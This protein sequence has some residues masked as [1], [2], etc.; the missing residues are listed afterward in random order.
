MVSSP[1]ILKNSSITAAFRLF[2]FQVAITMSPATGANPT[3]ADIALLA[4]IRRRSQAGFLRVSSD[5]LI[6]FEHTVE[7]RT[8]PTCFGLP[9]DGEIVGRSIRYITMGLYGDL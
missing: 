4:S 9:N 7:C 6:A 1:L 8:Y 5:L 2:A 3:A